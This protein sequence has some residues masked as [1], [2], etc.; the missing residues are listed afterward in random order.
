[1][2]TRSATALSHFGRGVAL[3]A[4][5]LA[6]RSSGP[7]SGRS[8]RP[9]RL[10]CQEAGA[11]AGSLQD[12]GA[13]EEP[14]AECEEPTRSPGRG[15]GVR[16]G[17]GDCLVQ[18]RFSPSLGPPTSP[19]RGAT[20]AL[21]SPGPARPIPRTGR[22]RAAGLGIRG[23]DSRSYA[24]RASSARRGWTSSRAGKECGARLRREQRW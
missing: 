3:S 23:S 5:S 4:C 6:A 20:S 21:P 11:P 16:G 13:E 17:R 8:S 22:L 12:G 7:A 1:M 9:S 14:A 10:L 24:T 19:W 2:R 15:L 18:A